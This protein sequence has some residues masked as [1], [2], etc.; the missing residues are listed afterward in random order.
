[1]Q[2]NTFGLNQITKQ[3]RFRSR[4]EVW[5]VPSGLKLAKLWKWAYYFFFFFQC[6]TPALLYRLSTNFL[7]AYRFKIWYK[8][9]SQVFLGLIVLK[10]WISNIFPIFGLFK[11]HLNISFIRDLVVF[12]IMIQ[13]C[14]CPLIQ[15][16]NIPRY[17]NIAG[18]N[19]KSYL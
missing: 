19:S 8:A 5:K 6:L 10:M 17:N 9:S 16:L 14:R 11:N 15:S 1:M 13:T 7:L 3:C 12:T 2:C 18:Y 4:W